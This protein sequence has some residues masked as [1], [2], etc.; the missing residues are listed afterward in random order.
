MWRDVHMCVFSTFF[1]FLKALK[2]V[3]FAW[4]QRTVPLPQNESPDI[5]HCICKSLAGSGQKDNSSPYLYCRPHLGS[6]FFNLGKNESS[7]SNRNC[8]RLGFMKAL[9]T[10]FSF[11]FPRMQASYYFL[12]RGSQA[13]A[14]SKRL[15]R[16]K[17][18][19][20]PATIRVCGIA[21]S[22]PGFAHPVSSELE[23]RLWH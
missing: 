20:G 6:S 14:V 23:T 9:V 7:S 15:F 3:S 4:N 17:R 12:T 22:E 11:L 21:A 5:L 16:Q 19:R 2:L 18:E 13:N 10:V 8:D 1:F